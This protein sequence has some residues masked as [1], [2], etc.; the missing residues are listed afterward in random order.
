[1]SLSLP[2]QEWQKKCITVKASIYEL[3]HYGFQPNFRTFHL[4]LPQQARQHPHKAGF[5]TCGRKLSATTVVFCVF[6]LCPAMGQSDLPW[7]TGAKSPR[8]EALH[9]QVESGKTAAVG[10]FWA[11]MTVR[12][13][14]IIEPVPG[15]ATHSLVTFIYRGSADTKL[16]VLDCQMIIGRDPSINRLTRLGASDVWFKT[17][18]VRNDMRLGYSFIPNPSEDAGNNPNAGIADPLN[19][20]AAPVAQYMGKSVLE[21]PDAP[22][23]PWVTPRSGAAAGK[24]EEL[25]IQ[26]KV[27][28][29]ERQAWIHTPLGFDASRKEPY[30]LLICFDGQVYASPNY[31]PVPTIVDNMIADGRIPAL[32]VVLI[33]QSPQPNRNIE[34]SNN[35]PFLN[36]VANELL[37]QVRQRWHATS[38]PGQTIVTG[39]SAGGLAAAFFAFRRSDVFGNVLSQSGAFWPGKERSDPEHEWL[40]QQFESSTKLPIRFVLQVGLLERGPSP[41]NGPSIL[42]TNRHLRSVLERKGYEVHYSEVAGGHEP[43]NWRGGISDGLLQLIG[44]DRRADGAH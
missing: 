33:G 12:H 2:A 38:D 36:F 11:D 10:Q 1:M 13:A 17:Y 30:P 32:I 41:G 8:I 31:M 28:D 40:T 29:S 37:P 16:V 14:P 21:L 22:P 42:E 25:R 39:S 3:M 18:S 44:V 7:S 43:L 19:P 35:Q 24:I 9:N 15:D 5:M 27:L 26:S 23:Q 6:L 20:K 4:T 34:L